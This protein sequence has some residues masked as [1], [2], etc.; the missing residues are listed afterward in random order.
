M[1]RLGLLLAFAA[2]NPSGLTLEVVIDD[3][4]IEKVELFVGEYCS[5]DCPRGTVPPQLPAMA[6]DAAFVVADQVPW[7]E[8]DFTDGVAGFRLESPHDTSLDIVVV[9]A[10]DAQDQIRWSASF[11]D[12][13]VPSNDAAHWRVTL[14]PTTPI[15]ATPAT[16]GSERIARWQ[17][18]SKRL[19]SCL[20]L[21]HWS[22]SAEPARELVVPDADRD[23]DEVPAAS[24]CAPWIPNANGA[25]PTVA[26]ASC[27]LTASVGGTSSVCVLGGPECNENGTQRDACVPVAGP[28]CM[29]TT[30]CA[31]AGTNDFEACVMTKISEG[32]NN[33]T[34]PYLECVIQLDTDGTSCTDTTFE[35]DAGAYL[36]GGSTK[37]RSMSLNDGG[38]PLGAFDYYVALDD[39]SKLKIE[40]FTEPCKAD[41]YFA[42]SSM[43]GTRL[44]VT[45]LELD[46]GNHLVVPL[47][48]DLKAGGCLED[49]HCTFF[50][51]NDAVFDSIWQCVGKDVAPRCAPD[52]GLGC[53]G[54]MCNGQCCGAGEACGP[55]GCMC[56]NTGSR[57]DGGD[58]CQTGLVMQ[59]QCGTTCCGITQPCPF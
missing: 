9:L 31:C 24:E 1:R 29:S 39:S 46:N 32:I 19:P 18:P 56:G 30:L 53:A 22:S 17:Q 45:A 58:T 42:G 3:P 20:L 38:I 57:C 2:C 28:H 47:R 4:G 13:P 6:V 34:M 41:F 16:A 27:L 33:S 12:V 8:T 48:V 25:W 26:E 40:S 7:T 50:R 14:S 52:P 55:N 5:G 49:S 10:Y 36:S 37:C 44:A 43:P 54:P 23:C 51:P 21:E 11:H 59:D 35:A 15:A